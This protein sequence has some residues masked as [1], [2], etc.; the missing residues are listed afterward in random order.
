MG[1]DR[2]DEDLQGTAAFSLTVS[3]VVG[4]G[5]VTCFSLAC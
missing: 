3:T 2:I 5:L 1:Q 4:F